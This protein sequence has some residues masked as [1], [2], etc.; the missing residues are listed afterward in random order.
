[1]DVFDRSRWVAAATLIV[2]LAGCT[3][4]SP[5]TA[6]PSASPALSAT[7]PTTPESTAPTTPPTTS[8]PAGTTSSADPQPPAAF[9]GVQLVR[10]GGIAGI[11]ETITIR[12]NGTW[13]RITTKGA[14]SNGKVAPAKLAQLAK[15]AADPRLQTEA[16]RAQPGRNK[17]ND[18][19]SYLLIV[20]YRMIRY[21]QCPSNGDKPPATIEMIGLVEDAAK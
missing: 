16:G 17:C 11:T 13:D 8:P 18:T 3:E 20:G 9:D 6:A 19:F 2:A 5:P 15:L 14:K 12:T 1:M 4:S 7:T 10:S 21:E